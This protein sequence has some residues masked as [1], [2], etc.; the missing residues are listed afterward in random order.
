LYLLFGMDV[1]QYIVLVG[2]RAENYKEKITGPKR[3]IELP[4]EELH[5]L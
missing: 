3:S 2:V 5:D 4:H 1:K